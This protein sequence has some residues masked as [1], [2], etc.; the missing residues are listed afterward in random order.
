MNIAIRPDT[1][2]IS[3]PLAVQA[4]LLKGAGGVLGKLWSDPVSL[5]VNG[6]MALYWVY[7]AHNAHKNFLRIQLSHESTNR[8]KELIQASGG[9]FQDVVNLT[10][11]TVYT[12][13]WLHS[14]S[15]ISL[16]RFAGIAQRIGYG[17]SAVSGLVDLGFCLHKIYVN[18]EKMRLTSSEI[19]RK[20]YQ[21]RVNW[22]QLKV[23][24]NVSFVAASVLSVMS[25]APTAAP[26]SV[27]VLPLLGLGCCFLVAAV[28]YKESITPEERKIEAQ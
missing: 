23:V 13:S 5:V 18:W 26:A 1:M 6:A 10:G 16:G 22:A 11:T 19:E 3:L 4:P 27:A 15:V 24:S 14:T 7:V 17:S 8:K 28:K 20:T 21:Q 2:R 25:L 12:A 9:L